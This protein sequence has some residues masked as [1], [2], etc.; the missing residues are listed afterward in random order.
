MK[1]DSRI[2]FISAL[3]AHVAV[4]AL[5]ATG[6]RRDETRLLMSW[7]VSVVIILMRRH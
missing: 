6:G 3:I 2:A 4:C 1:M 5:L 7:R